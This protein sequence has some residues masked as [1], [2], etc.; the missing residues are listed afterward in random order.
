MPVAR[1]LMQDIPEDDEGHAER[2][3]EARLQRV[4]RNL[5]HPPNRLLV[6]ILKEAKAPDSVVEVAKNLQCPLCA[7]RARTSLAR[8]ANPFRARELG[9]IVA[10]DFS[11]RA[12]PSKETLMVLRFIDEAS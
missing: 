10:M 3:T 5:G 2:S 6:Q 1:E 8:P 12:T 7:R 11:F 4:R 9:H